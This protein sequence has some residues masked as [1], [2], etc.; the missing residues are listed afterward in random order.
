MWCYILF[1]SIHSYQRFVPVCWPIVCKQA[2]K[3]S[4]SPNNT[5]KRDYFTPAKAPLSDTFF[6]RLTAI[7]KWIAPPPDCYPALNSYSRSILILWRFY[8]NF[9][10]VAPCI[11]E[12]RGFGA[13][14]VKVCETVS[15]TVTCYL[16]FRAKD[17]LF[18][19]KKKRKNTVN[20]TSVHLF[21]VAFCCSV[22]APGWEN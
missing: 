20:P 7:V 18:N 14:V 17:T 19:V 15:L 1:L 4:I 11:K 16:L 22:S 13:C 21:S 6:L 12:F 10:G 5:K 2:H 9:N 3:F 8:H